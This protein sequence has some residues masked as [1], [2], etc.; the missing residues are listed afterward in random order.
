MIENTKI[1]LNFLYIKSMA[2]CIL[3][4]ILFINLTLANSRDYID[5][6]IITNNNPYPEK[7]FIHTQGVNYMA[8]LDENLEPYWYVKSN[9]LGGGIDFKVNNNYLSYF[10]KDYKYWITINHDMQEVDTLQSTSGITDYHDMIILDN[11]NYILQAYDSLFVN[12]SILVDG[13][14]PN[15]LIKGILRIQEFNQNHDLL[16]DWFALDHLNIQNYT[17][18]NLT[19]NAITWMHGNSIEID[20]DNNLILSNRRSSEI[21]KIDRNTGEVLWILGGPTNEYEVL[22]DQLGGFSKQHDVRRLNNGNI[23]LFD[24]GNEH[25]PPTSRVVEYEINEE[26]KITRLVWEFINPYNEFSVS[27]GSS[28][29]LLN[30]NTLINWGNTVSAARIMEVDYDKNICLEL[31]YSSGHSYKVRKDDWQFDIPMLIGDPNLD[32]IINV[33]DIMYQVDFILNNNNP[34]NLFN[35]FK[36]DLNKDESIDI[37][38]VMR[39]VTIIIQ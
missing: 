21:I 34:F 33:L 9:T 11:G 29:R 10:N 2:I 13:G 5:F 22:D 17:N 1:T 16:F 25:N 15:A 37:L 19:N 30:G 24:N 14:H 35:L 27:M 20:Y 12:M 39:L 26:E 23:L 32:N 4:L 28:Q 38:D 8:I 7:I 31:E 36:I 6:E 18:L 3:Y